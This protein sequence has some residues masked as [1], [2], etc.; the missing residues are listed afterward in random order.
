MKRNPNKDEER[1]LKSARR[2]LSNAFPNPQR[3]GCPSEAALRAMAVQPQQADTA[4]SDHLAFCSP[5]LNRYMDFLAGLR[6]EQ[7]GQ[8]RSLW[9][10]VLPWPK[11]LPA[12]I[13]AASVVVLVLSVAG[14]F[15]GIHRKS[16]TIDAPSQIEIG[17][18]P[19][20]FSPFTLDLRDLSPTRAPT[21]KGD[22]RATITLPRRPLEISVLLPIGSEEGAY[23]LSLKAG[24]R[25]VWAAQSEAHF[26]EQKITLHVKV[27]LAQFP[28]GSY[29]FE[30]KSTTGFHLRQT[31]ALQS[32]RIEQEGKR[33]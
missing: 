23:H 24:D 9:N 22:H 4:V 6:G 8:R 21:E 3:V 29:A 5:C 33:Q 25:T 10:E 14:Y 20:V 32:P 27:D 17:L 18:R 12:R 28:P 11:S 7:A 19:V 13:G 1:L 2:Y 31:V 26:L 15:A 30:V 16:P